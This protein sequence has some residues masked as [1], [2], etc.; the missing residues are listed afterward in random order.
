MG[1]RRKRNPGNVHGVFCI[2][3]PSG[4]SS[5][6]L[7]RRIGRELGTS[8]AG[9]AGTLDPFATGILVVL[10]GEATK[11]SRWITAH[12]KEYIA[13]LQ[14]GSETDTLDREGEIVATSAV[15]PGALTRETVQSECRSFVGVHDQVAPVFSAVRVYGKRLMNEARAGRD[16]TPP[17]RRV[18]CFALDVLDF[19]QS[20]CQ[21]TIKLHCAK[22]Y[23]VRA[24]ARDLGR[25]L[26]VGAHL[27]ELRRTRSGPFSLDFA[28]TPENVAPGD[29]VSLNEVLEEIPMVQLDAQAV[30]HI[31]HG[32]RIAA[33]ENAEFALLTD[34]D[35]R[36]LAMAALTPDGQ[37]RVERGLNWTRSATS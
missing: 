12:D 15:P 28:R 25:K 30:E 33:S 34:R 19:D 11:L 9:H 32:R 29:S 16:V 35:D 27:V 18:E 5:A 24:F 26:G 2:D 4:P 21:A 8:R 13:T 23:Y 3:K 36:P 17:V 14:F 10:L 37:W 22:G 31:K 20:T 6:W 1:R 7:A